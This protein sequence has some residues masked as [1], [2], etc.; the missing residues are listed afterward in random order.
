MVWAFFFGLIQGALLASLVNSL[1][2]GIFGSTLLAF[3]FMFNGFAAFGGIILFIV[4]NAI[5]Y[6]FFSAKAMKR[7]PML[8]YCGALIGFVLL[9]FL[10]Q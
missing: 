2:P 3:D 7:N 10:G 5:F 4:A 6:M 9:F 8:F 1:M